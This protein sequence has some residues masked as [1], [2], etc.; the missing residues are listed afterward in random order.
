M[1]LS[2]ASYEGNNN[3]LD[4]YVFGTSILPYTS[5]GESFVTTEIDKASLK[6]LSLLLNSPACLHPPMHTLMANA[7]PVQP[8]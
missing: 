3:N 5:L 7:P 1:H 6:E 2:L 8:W 4:P